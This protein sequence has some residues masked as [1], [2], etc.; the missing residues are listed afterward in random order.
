MTIISPAYHLTF[1]KLGREPEKQQMS[2]L[3]FARQVNTGTP[4]RMAR[5]L[6]IELPPHEPEFAEG[7]T[8]GSGEGKV[9]FDF[10][11][12]S[13]W[14]SVDWRGLPWHDVTLLR[15]VDDASTVPVTAATTKS[16]NGGG[17]Q[18]P[19]GKKND[20]KIGRRKKTK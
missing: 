9:D 14:E 6:R 8:W 10:G 7:K 1:Q 5:S 17:R 15:L 12:R 3:N 11:G 20:R 4:V 19:R 2:Q 16:G 13:R 18:V